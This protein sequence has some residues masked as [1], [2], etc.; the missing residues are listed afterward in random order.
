[1][2]VECAGSRTRLCRRSADFSASS[3]PANSQLGVPV[4]QKSP[5]P[6]VGVLACFEVEATLQVLLEFRYQ[7]SFLGLCSLVSCAIRFG[8]ASRW[9]RAFC[10][11]LL[12]IRGDIC[13]LCEGHCGIEGKSG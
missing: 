10:N 12:E 9:C 2:F 3:E 13:E 5:D 4:V 11:E 1:M 8:A 7:G 6:L